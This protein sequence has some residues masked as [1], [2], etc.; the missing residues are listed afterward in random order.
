[1]TEICYWK[2]Q[3]HVQAKDAD[4]QTVLLSV[5]VLC[6]IIT[7]ST[8]A[9]I[10]SYIR[11]I[12]AAVATVCVNFASRPLYKPDQ[13]CDLHR[14]NTSY[15]YELHKH[16]FVTNC[17]LKCSKQYSHNQYPLFSYSDFITVSLCSNWCIIILCF[18]SILEII[19]IIIV[20]I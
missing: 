11:N 14:Q 4:N 13:P 2:Y 20:P 12:N 16:S 3:V 5:R 17:L 18:L 8:S 10:F 15:N 6:V 1:L 7:R 19:I 9:A